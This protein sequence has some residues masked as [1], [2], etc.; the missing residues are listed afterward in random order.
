MM[1]GAP[2][3]AIR[4]CAYNVRRDASCPTR[5]SAGRGTNLH[6]RTG[7]RFVGV[8]IPKLK[9]ATMSVN[10]KN[11]MLSLAETL[12]AAEELLPRFRAI[13]HQLKYEN[14][15]VCNTEMFFIYATVD[16]LR[17]QRILESGRARGQSTFV[18]AECFPAAQVISVEF[19]ATSADASFA[20]A[21]LKDRPNVTCLFGDSRE[22]LP[23]QLQEGD[24]VV[25]D[26]PKGFRALRLA[27]NLLRTGRPSVVFLHD[28]AAPTAERRFLERNLADTFFSD[29]PDFT[30]RYVLLEGKVDAA[31]LRWAVFACIPGGRNRPYRFLL[32]KLSFVRAVALAPQKISDFLAR[33][34]LGRNA[35]ASR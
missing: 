5:P 4:R 20:E 16:A 26:G 1:A 21:R 34:V 12:D 19:D 3:L 18:L 10:R 2:S 25:I 22:L 9:I 23:Q 31:T 8:N 13:V 33:L 7:R 35:V 15:G 32:W 14:R 24:V 17:P 29:H 6:R 30:D 28:F 11:K 27:F